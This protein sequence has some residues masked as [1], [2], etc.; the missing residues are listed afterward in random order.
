M[1]PADPLRLQVLNR[2]KTVLKAITAGDNYFFTPYD[3]ILGKRKEEEINRYPFY[4]IVPQAG[5]L[6]FAGQHLYNEKM[7]IFVYGFTEDNND[8]VAVNEKALRDIR[9][10][11]GDD[12]KGQAAGT[13]GALTVQTKMDESPITDY[14]INHTKGYFR[15]TVEAWIEGGFGKL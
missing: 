8:V 10:A 6:E 9:K 12:A 14:D 13:L 3:V 11:V 4:M 1:S 7:T 15:L 2:I 5:S